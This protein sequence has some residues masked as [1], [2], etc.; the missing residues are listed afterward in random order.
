MIN[1]TTYKDYGFDAFLKRRSIPITERQSALSVQN[2]FGSGSIT[3][4]QL[5][6]DSLTADTYSAVTLNITGVATIDTL[7]IQDTNNSDQLSIIWNENDTA[8]R[9]LNLKVSGGNR[10]LDLD[11][12]LTASTVVKTTGDTMTGDL[13]TTKVTVGSTQLVKS[14]TKVV[15]PSGA[16]IGSADYVCDGTADDVEIQAALDALP[17]GGGEVKLLNGTFNIATVIALDSNQTLRGCGKNT[18]LTTTS[19][20]GILDSWGGSGTE[21]VNTTISDLQIDGNSVATRGVY[22]RYSDNA[23]VKN[24]YIHSIP[25]SNNGIS[26]YYASGCLIDGCDIR[27]CYSGISF[28]YCDDTIITS[29]NFSANRYS[30]VTL[31]STCNRLSI[32]DNNSSGNSFY[33][34]DC[35]GDNN[36]VSNNICTTNTRAGIYTTTITN[37]VISGNNSSDNSQEGIF[38]INGD[39]NTV[40]GN[41][42]IGNYSSN[43]HLENTAS[44]NV[45]IGNT[46]SNSTADAGI[47]IESGGGSASNSNI[48]SGNI[49]N[50]NDTYGIRLYEA[51]LSEIINNH[52][53]S[54]NLDGITLSNSSHNNSISNNFLLANGQGTDDTYDGI[55]L[56]TANYNLLSGNTCLDGGGAAQPKY[57]IHIQSVGTPTGNIVML[58]NLYDSGKTGTLKDEG[59]GTVVRNNYS[60][61]TEA[62]GTGSIASGT[63]ADIITHGLSVTPTINDISVTLSEDPDNTPGAIWVDTIGATNFTVNCENDPGASNLDFGWRVQVL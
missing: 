59:T 58:N 17:V 41:C 19:A 62:S 2:T 13:V 8:D 30:G 28:D 53:Y 35:R 61:V 25:D 11:E 3:S 10:T 15:A 48:I 37:S 21:K 45:V 9:T 39:N 55:N 60:Y 40:S 1:Q 46:C 31:Q 51:S 32:I 27:G 50:E 6:V 4:E 52:C 20:I 44:Y 47:F 24:L 18:I 63:T 22:L 38:V 16:D 54:N 33:G 56:Q 26:G 43:I 29:N 7:K 42:C 12:N 57:G 49:C 34:L 5:D 14:V 23:I 36:V